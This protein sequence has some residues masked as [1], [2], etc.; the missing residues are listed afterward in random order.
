[1]LKKNKF[2]ITM[3]FIIP[4]LVSLILG[5]QFKGGQ[6]RN[7][8]TVIVDMDNSSCSRM[9]AGEVKNNE[10]FDV[11]YFSG[12]SQD[13]E[14]LIKSNKA[15]VGLMIPKDFGKDLK[16][17]KAP[18]V[19]VMYDGS[20]M[21]ITSAAKSRMSEILLTLKSAFLMK[22]MEGK[23]NITSEKAYDY[24]LPMGFETRFVNN[25]TRNY[26]DFL[27]PGMLAALIQVGL[28][29]AGAGLIEKKEKYLFKL[30]FRNLVL[31]LFGCLSLAVSMLIQCLIFKTPFTGNLF[32][33][34]ALTFI[35]STAVVSVGILVGLII[36]ARLF[37]AQ[38]AAIIMLPSSIL[39]GYTWPLMA[40]PEGYQI[41]GKFLPYTYYAESL[42]DLTVKNIGFN[43]VSGDFKWFLSFIAVVWILILTANI[44]KKIIVVILNKEKAKKSNLFCLIHKLGLVKQ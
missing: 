16:E 26:G 23:L 43:S 13:L 21:S 17:Y 3:I 32:G 29:M 20:Q 15:R 31:G 5:Y 34:L 27:I 40:M 24:V 2:I 28:V 22:T 1:M 14:K 25:S 18:K 42:R 36:P 6:I 12:N 44:I 19:L 8:P 38:V 37:A 9:I 30:F 35:F 39:G 7:V 33:G 41:L 10:I 11:K 4:I